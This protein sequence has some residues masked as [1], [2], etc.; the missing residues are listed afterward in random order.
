MQYFSILS[1]KL[2]TTYEKE[3]HVLTIIKSFFSS[4]FYSIFL[5][6]NQ[7]KTE[8]IF[9]RLVQ[10]KERLLCLIK[11]TLLHC[12][13]TLLVPLDIHL[14]FFFHQSFFF[15]EDLMKNNQLIRLCFCSVSLVFLYVTITPI[16]PPSILSLQSRLHSYSCL[17]FL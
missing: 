1:S 15:V 2:V 6:T 5:F 12:K 3:N 10:K 14:R 9:K 11:H 4:R 13:Q 16:A 17:P 8:R 7:K